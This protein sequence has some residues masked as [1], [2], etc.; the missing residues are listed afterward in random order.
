MTRRAA[1]IQIGLAFLAATGL[2]VFVVLPVEHGIDPTGF[3]RWSGLS[4]LRAATDKYAVSAGGSPVEAMRTAE[5]PFR[6]DVV[7]F[8]IRPVR[9]R[10]AEIEY[11]LAM[12]AGDVVVY[13]WAASDEL[14]FE[15][16]GHGHVPDAQGQASVLTYLS[17]SAMQSHGYLVA[18][19]EGI[20]G[21]FFQSVEPHSVTVELRLAGHYQLQ[22]QP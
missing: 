10:F 8:E 2:S 19:M 21:W 22:K 5:V 12:K 3:G 14:Y 18:P 13:S 15:F 1:L 20:H 11:K 17:D 16:H 6:T 7:R 4:K 9:G